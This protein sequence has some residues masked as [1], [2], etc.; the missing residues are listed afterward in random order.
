MKDVLQLRMPTN[1]VTAAHSISRLT[2]AW[3]PMIH[4][5]PFFSPRIILFAA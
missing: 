1:G 5:E 3:H 4:R 2:E